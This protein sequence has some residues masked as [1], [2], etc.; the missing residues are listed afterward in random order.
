MARVLNLELKL[1]ESSK[2]QFYVKFS[3]V[4]FSHNKLHGF[5]AHQP[6]SLP[7]PSISKDYRS[8]L[9]Q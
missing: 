1:W 5:S 9:P 2:I 8:K 7:L 4:V 6:F 3:K